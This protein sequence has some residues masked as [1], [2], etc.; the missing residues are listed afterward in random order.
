MAFYSQDNDIFC[1]CLGFA[2]FV[3]D[4]FGC[5]SLLRR[6]T[7]YEAS[8]AESG[9][10]C[11]IKRLPYFKISRGPLIWRDEFDHLDYSKWTPMI[12]GWRGSHAFQIYVNRSQNVYVRDGNLF[13]KPT[14]TADRYGPEFLYNGT[15]DLTLEGCNVNW[16]GGC[17]VKSGADI[18]QPIQSARIHTKNSFSFTY[19]FVEVRARMPKGDWIWPAVWMSP[20]ESVYGSNPRS[21]EIDI[22]EVRS[23][24]NLSCGSKSYGRQLSGTTLHWG[25]DSH[26]N[27]HRLTYWQKVQRNPDFSSDFHLFAMEWLPTGFNFYV[28]NDLIGYVTPPEGGFWEMGG[29]EGQNIWNVTGNGTRISPFD[30]PFHLILDVA[31]GG[32]MFPDWCV[33]QPFDRPLEKPWKMSDRVQMRPFWEKRMNWLPTWNS[34][35]EDNT[36]RID[37]IRVYALDQH[38]RSHG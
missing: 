10:Y 7:P 26:H 4:S 22:T 3:S 32:N 19:G 5:N 36:M 23:N 31:V 6:G 29:F 30:R 27:G 24:V 20:T 2:F 13:I 38:H 28:D 25:P 14:F 8:S 33:N 17:I 21:G 18:I 1:L 11:S 35:S 16:G 9:R 12:S 15:I 37:Y 34:E